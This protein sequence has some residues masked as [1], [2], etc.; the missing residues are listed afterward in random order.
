MIPF[1]FDFRLFC[2]L[3][4]AFILCTIIGTVSHEFGH[5]IVAELMGYDAT[6][7][8]GSTSF[9]NHVDYRQV[10]S[11]SPILI[12]IGG[13]VQTILT[14][15]FGLVILWLIRRSFNPAIDLRLP[16]WFF[17]F[18]SLFWLR[19]PANLATW[20]IGY[21][22]SGIFGLR[23]DEIGIARYFQLPTWSIV[24]LTAFM[25]FLVL[26]IIIFKFIPTHH[27]FTF[28]LSGLVGGIAGYILWLYMI[29]KYILP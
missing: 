8:Y 2:W 16:Q 25:G 18:L 14:G 20:I 17:I 1:R 4:L 5:Y 11:L 7:H 27:R 10:S 21:F 15:T 13:P 28:I 29:G 19:F 12:T 6:I 9:S 24:V 22:K 23:G 3:S 26:T